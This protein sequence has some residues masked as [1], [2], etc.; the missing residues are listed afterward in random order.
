MS[1]HDIA[2]ELHKP[3]RR[4]FVR[5]RIH[6]YSKNDLFHSDL[7]D[8]IS[9][10]RENRGFRYILCVIDCFTK[11]AWCVPLKS[12]KG[13][14]VAAAIDGILANRRPNLLQVDR[15][16]EYYNKNVNNVMKKY[17][18]KM[19]ST[20][21]TTKAAIAE[22]FIRTI[23]EKMFRQ[24]TASGSHEWLTI[25]PEL[26]TNYNN[27]VHRTI[28]MTPVQADSNPSRVKHYDIKRTTE[29]APRMRRF[30]VGDKVRI[31]VYKGVFTK[32]YLPNWSTEVFTII[33]VNKTAP[34]T[35][36]LEDYTGSPISGGFYAEEICKTVYPNDY[37]VERVI[38]TK[39]RRA[40]VKW[41]GF[42]STHN[43]W[44]DKNDLG[45]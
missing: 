27:S 20:Y 40:F 17:D 32:G 19:Y 7:I 11:Y 12:K 29:A 34:P 13:V 23:K 8:L 2:R 9:Y 45:V 22:R 6:V 3:A 43:S 33:K 1:K 30:S 42:D 28:G 24:F 14:E 4:N 35:Y 16:T 39:G 15:G 36:L 41:L 38:R 21:S 10:S 25:L 31:S 26:M 18:I 44:L 37:L 5:R